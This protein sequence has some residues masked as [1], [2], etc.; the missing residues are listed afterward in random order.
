MSEIK[1][2]TPGT[3]CWAELAAQDADK[4]KEFYT[5]LF[6]WAIT[7]MPI[8]ENM[9]YSMA[10]INGKDAGAMYQMW[11]EQREQG[12][13]PHWSSFISV[14]NVDESVKKARALGGTVIVEPMDVFDA[15]RMASIIDPAGAVVS[16]WQP[17]KHIGARIINE[18]GA[19]C[20]NEL[21]TEDTVKAGAFYTGLFGWTAN[22]QDMGGM[23][24]TIFMNGEKPAGGMM[25]IDKNCV[26]MP[27][28]WLVYFA[29]NDCDGCIDEARSLGGKIL[30]GPMDIAGV[31]RIASIID[32]QGAAFAVIKPEQM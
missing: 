15:G 26:E 6:G 20:W 12:V 9:V 18:H 7:D 28:N 27:P 24:Y 10:S 2:Y 30:A 29:V 1:E 16:L 17:V 32:S 13:P 21:L 14:S 31:G 25:K 4:A 8:G 23:I 22:E 5:K 3:F 19:S 11:S